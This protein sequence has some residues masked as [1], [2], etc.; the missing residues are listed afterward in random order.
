MSDIKIQP[1]ATGTATVTLTAP[2]TNTARTITFPDSTGT[3]LDSTST[4]D[5][6]K[7]SG[8]LP[9]ISGAN[10]TSIPAA[11]ITGTLPA[12]SAAN[13][14]SIPA[15]NITGTLPAISGASLTGVRDTT[16]GRKNVIINGS[17]EIAQRGTTSGSLAA[18]GGSFNYHTV[19]R[20]VYGRNTSS[21]VTMTQTAD[22]PVGL[23]NCLQIDVTTAD[24]SPSGYVRVVHRLEGQ[25]IIHFGMGLAGTRYITLSFWH[26]HTKTG[27]NTVCFQNWANNRSYVAEYTQSVSDTWERATITLTA[28]TTGTWVNTEAGS[29]LLQWALHSH[30]TTS[31]GSWE[32][33]NKVSTSGQVNHLD[34]TSNYFR[35]TGVQMELGSVATDFEFRSHGEEL[36]LC[37]RYYE[38]FGNGW[39]A[40]GETGSS[41]VFFG[42]FKVTK[43]TDPTI[44][45]LTTNMRMYEWGVADRD[46]STVSVNSNAMRKNGGHIKC[47]G[48]SSTSTGELYGLGYNTSGT[49]GE[50]FSADSE[51]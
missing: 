27:I 17:M 4:L 24:A 15:A 35:I 21:V 29:M 10:L 16:D 2:V 33:G 48:F 49:D 25:N 36:A 23:K 14:T 13:L 38:P 32:A 45:V 39:T 9:A 5:A 8:N 51:L 41:T 12:L 7:L 22:A 26:K 34:S 28:D 19:D 43:R 18:S 40:R 46:A 44:G 3:I 31:A 6:T 30:T 47:G 1:S 37:Q 20:W 50:P 11:N 42:R